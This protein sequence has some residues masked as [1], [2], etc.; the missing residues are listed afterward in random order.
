VQRARGAI[1]HA[2][3]EEARRVLDA[4]EFQARVSPDGVPGELVANAR[5]KFDELMR[6]NIQ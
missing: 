5:L 3:A 4:L 6:A 2:G 1:T